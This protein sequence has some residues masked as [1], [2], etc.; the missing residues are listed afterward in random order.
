MARIRSVHPSLFTDEAWVSCTPMARLLYIGLWTDA[1]DQGLF[2]WR[3]IQLKMRLF[4]GDNTDV[5]PLLD[6]LAS[7]ELVARLESGGKKLGAIRQFR[8]Y[9]RPK[10]P[11]RIFVLPPEWETYVG[12]GDDSAELGDDEAPPVPHRTPTDSE[13]P[14]QMEDGG[15]R[16]EVELVVVGGARDTSAMPMVDDWPPVNPMAVLLALVE[17]AFL[18]PNKSPGLVTTAGRLAAWKRDGASWQHDVV[19]VVSSLCAK[20]R[21]PIS[22]WKFFD[23]AIAR[24]IADNR[25]VLEIPEGQTHERTGKYPQAGNRE[26]RLSRSYAGAMAALDGG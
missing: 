6:E 14:P 2:E 3:P 4:P 1:D 11:N 5:S 26:D 21:S 23:A 13:L 20:Q 7:V 18:D 15:C 22:T 12:L 8:K 16:R 9:Q 10:K 19:P 24:S 25:R 17:C